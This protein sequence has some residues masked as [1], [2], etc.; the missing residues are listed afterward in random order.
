MILNTQMA[1]YGRVVKD[2]WTI[3]DTRGKGMK[4]E[5][6]VKRTTATWYT[7]AVCWQEQDWAIVKMQISQEKESPL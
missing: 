4:R 2:L 5:R 7:N 6:R 3:Q 1:S